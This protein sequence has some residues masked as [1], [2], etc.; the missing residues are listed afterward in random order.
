ML[1]STGRGT[2]FALSTH[3]CLLAGGGTVS[4]GCELTS[5]DAESVSLGGLPKRLG[6]VLFTRTRVTESLGTYLGMS[7]IF[8]RDSRG[9][10]EGGEEKGG[11]ANARSLVAAVALASSHRFGGSS[12]QL[13]WDS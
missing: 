9:S 3:G 13:L 1:S 4:G 6:E 10:S 7:R 8:A 2:G 12:L 5:H 11:G